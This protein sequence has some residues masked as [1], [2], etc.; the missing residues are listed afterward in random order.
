MA[1]ACCLVVV[2]AQGGFRD[3]HRHRFYPQYPSFSRGVDVAQDPNSVDENYG[4]SWGAT[5]NNH[6]QQY[7]ADFNFNSDEF[8]GGGAGGSFNGAGQGQ[9]G[10]FNGGGFNNPGGN[11]GNANVPSRPVPVTT[12]PPTTTAPVTTA[13]PAVPSQQPGRHYHPIDM[14]FFLQYYS[15]HSAGDSNRLSATQVVYSDEF[16]MCMDQCRTTNEWNPVCGTDNNNYNNLEKL[17]CA[18]SC[19]GSK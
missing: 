13:A 11:Q 12:A 7:N 17:N 6:H 9:G 5:P 18:N 19:G 16:Y 10:N 1:A 15:S 8:L 2:T 4:W 14:I 3:G